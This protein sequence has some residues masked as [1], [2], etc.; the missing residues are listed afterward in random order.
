MYR[1]RARERMMS[2]ISSER[3]PLGAWVTSTDP[4]TSMILGDLGFDFIVID[5][6]HGVLGDRDILNHVRSA[7]ATGTIALQ[8]MGAN[9][10]RLIQRALDSGVEGIIVPKVATADQIRRTVHMSRYARGGR[11]QCQVV[12]ATNWSQDGWSDFVE[13]SNSQIIVIPLIETLEGYRNYAEIAAV[14]GVDFAFFGY[15]DLALDI[16]IDMYT[17]REKLVPYWEEVKRISADAGVHVGLPLGEPFRG[18]RWGTAAGDLNI[19]RTSA[20]DRLR[21]ARELYTPEVASAP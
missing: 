21:A 20:R 12:P 6:E 19:L 10:P 2:M 11:G 7:R 17:E 8:R 1:P 13:A 5:D 3:T 18:A 9:D 14:D 4:S 15:A 16:G